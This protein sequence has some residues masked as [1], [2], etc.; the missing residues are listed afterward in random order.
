M[1]GFHTIHQRVDVADGRRIYTVGLIMGLIC[2]F[3]IGWCL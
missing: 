2:G 3:V 1:S